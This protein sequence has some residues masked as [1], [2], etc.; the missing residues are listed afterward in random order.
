MEDFD[1]FAGVR[2][3]FIHTKKQDHEAFIN[4]LLVELDGYSFI[5]KLVVKWITNCADLNYS[6]AWNLFCMN[7]VLVLYWNMA[8]VF[9]V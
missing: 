5:F 1:L 9:L 4:Q 3:K 2:G 8:L 7:R 6:K